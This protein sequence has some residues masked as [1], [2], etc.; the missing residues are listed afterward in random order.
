VREIAVPDDDISP[1]HAMGTLSNQFIGC[2]GG[3][4]D[5]VHRVY[6]MSSDGRHIVHSHGGQP[7]PDTRQY[8]VPAVTWQSMIMSLW[9]VA[10]VF[11]RRVTLL[12]LTLE[13]A[14]HI[15][16]RD[17]LKRWPC[18]LYLDA[19]RHLYV[20]NNEWDEQRRKHTAGRVAVFSV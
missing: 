4:A 20:A 10:D 17:Q 5:P 8:N 9:F 14:C 18:R 3:L 2:H 11:I 13:Y 6:M 15:V 7:G 1:W 16:S 19:K 12:S